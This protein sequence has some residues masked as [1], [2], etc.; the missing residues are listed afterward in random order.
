MGST[1]S[2]RCMAERAWVLMDWRI[3]FLVRLSIK[4][5]SANTYPD[6]SMRYQIYRKHNHMRHLIGEIIDIV[7]PRFQIVDSEVRCNNKSNFPIKTKRKA[8]WQRVQKAMCNHV[9]PVF[10]L[11]LCEKVRLQNVV[12]HKMTQD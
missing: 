12:S 7:P 3:R 10:A 8:E 4:Y 1:E 9:P 6:S 5:A 11:G 2:T